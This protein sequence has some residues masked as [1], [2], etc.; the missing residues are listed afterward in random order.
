MPILKTIIQ[1]LTH[2]KNMI[3][4]SAACSS[5]AA[6]LIRL[7]LLLLLFI[8]LCVILQLVHGLVNVI[9]VILNESINCEPRRDEQVTEIEAEAKISALTK[10]G[11]LASRA[12][13]LDQMT[14]IVGCGSHTSI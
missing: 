7:L 1:S 8:P 13:H 11:N 10:P 12:L 6:R 2:I 14:P 3:L 5:F 9:I 4:H